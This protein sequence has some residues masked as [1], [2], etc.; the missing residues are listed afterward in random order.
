MFVRMNSE[1]DDALR[2]GGPVVAL[3]STIISHGMPYPQNLKTAR[4]VESTVREAG[5]VPA[6]VAILDGAFQVGLTPEELEQFAKTADV[7]KASRRDVAAML[8]TGKPAATTV[9]TTMIGAAMAG[10]RV[11]AT[12]GTGGVHRGAEM[13]MDISADLEELARTPVAVVSAGVKSILDIGRTLEYLE[14]VGVPVLGFGTDEF[15]AFYTRSS[16]LPVT[17]R[18]DTPAEIARVLD[19]Q[20]K[21]GLGGGVLVANPIPEA[22]ALERDYIEGIIEQAVTEAGAKGVRGKD[23]TPYLLRRITEISGGRSLA[24]NIELVLNNARVAGEIAV[25]LSESTGQ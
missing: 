24:S 7:A 14:T 21:S 5:A 17:A 22:V 1:V 4:R 8:A 2:R 15:P 20:W 6:T 11:F 10:I 9:A 3:E 16:G 19:V 12:G 13:T 23:V 18:F 25:A